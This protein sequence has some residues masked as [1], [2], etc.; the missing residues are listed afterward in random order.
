MK[1]PTATNNTCQAKLSLSE[2]FKQ[3]LHKQYEADK[4]QLRAECRKKSIELWRA[5]HE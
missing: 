5:G 1:Y 2:L 3:S 4:E